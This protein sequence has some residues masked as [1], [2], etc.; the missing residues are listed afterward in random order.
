MK[1]M[2]MRCVEYKS[3]D[4]VVVTVIIDVR[5]GSESGAAPQGWRGTA[6]LLR[7]GRRTAMARRF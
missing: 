6:G 4:K 2:G 7:K 3:L 1:G 5:L